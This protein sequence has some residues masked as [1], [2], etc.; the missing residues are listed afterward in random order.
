M[1]KATGIFLSILFAII[2]AIL[3]MW[4]ANVLAHDTYSVRERDFKHEPQS[5][6]QE[7]NKDDIEHAHYAG[8]GRG[9]IHGFTNKQV[10]EWHRERLPPPPKPEETISPPETIT[11]LP[12]Q[13]PP[14]IDTGT[15]GSGTRT[16]QTVTT[17]TSAPTPESVK[18]FF[19][20]VSTTPPEPPKEMPEIEE[21]PEPEPVVM[22]EYH[23]Y[24]FWKGYTLVGF[25]VLKPE[26]ETIGDFY[27]AHTFFDSES[28]GIIVK[29]D[30]GWYFYNGHGPIGEIPITPNLGVAVKLD[31]AHY[32]GMRGMAVAGGEMDLHIGA[33]LVGLP[34]IPS[35]YKRP[36]DFLNDS[37]C[38]VIV[39]KQGTFYAV[40]KA[41]DNGDDL[42]S[43]GQALL[44]IASTEM[45]LDL[46]SSIAA[47]PNAY[48]I[49]K[50]PWGKIKSQ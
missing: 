30:E 28:E 17:F 8:D 16:V 47:A 7:Q 37:I 19:D 24:Q 10:E 43:A 27:E 42:L 9:V 11:P 5:E 48:R 36:S 26:I 40:G 29:I 32:L 22:L 41:G 13:Q 49:L 44:I 3:V 31:W 39:E 1:S 23:D 50:T 21:I 20:E 15:V 33:N 38:L 34:E 6:W 35:A 12:P 2:L 25:P 18:V 4:C 45:T 46:S 14:P